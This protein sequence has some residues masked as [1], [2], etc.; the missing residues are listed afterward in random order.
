MDRDYS[1]LNENIVIL[2]GDRKASLAIELEE[3]EKG[4]HGGAKEAKHKKTTRKTAPTE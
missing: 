2:V 3:K 4:G 1:S